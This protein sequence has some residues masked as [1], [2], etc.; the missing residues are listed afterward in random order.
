[1]TALAFQVSYFYNMLFDNL[2]S[3]DHLT[4]E[5]PYIKVGHKFK[6][7]D[8]ICYLFALMYYY[9]GIKDNIMYS[10]TQILYIK[11]YN[12]DSDLNKIMD[13]TLAF[14]T[15]DSNGNSLSLAE[16]ENIFDINKA[17]SEAD[18]NYNE[19]FK[20][21]RMKAFNLDVDIDELDA[22]LSQFQ[23]SLD[24]F[25]VY[26]YDQAIEHGFNQIITLRNFYSLNN[27]FYQKNIFSDALLPT[28]Y[29]NEIK[30]GFDYMLY[31]KT[32]INNISGK[33]HEYIICKIAIDN[34][35]DEPKEITL[36]NYNYD[37]YT[38]LIQ[39]NHNAN[40]SI[41]SKYMELLDG[42]DGHIFVM[43]NKHYAYHDGVNYAIYHKYRKSG[44]DYILENPDYYIYNNS[45]Y[46]L[47]NSNDLNEKY[48]NC[49]N[50]IDDN[51]NIISRFE[52]DD[53]YIYNDNNYILNP[54]TVNAITDGSDKRYFI[55][56]K[57][58]QKVPPEECYILSSD[59]KFVPLINTN[60][61]DNKNGTYNISKCFVI[62]DDKTIYYEKDNNGNTIYYKKLVDYY[63]E[64]NCY[65]YPENNIDKVYIKNKNGEYIFCTD[66][67]Y[68]KVEDDYI[69]ITNDKFFYTDNNNRKILKFGD[70]YIYKNGKYILDPDN[71]Y[72]IV[73][74][75][76]KKEYVLVKDLDKYKNEE[77]SADN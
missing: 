59:G 43:N 58:D 20:Y 6:F 57:E 40:V 66:K 16:R 15:K 23:L 27:S 51:G 55:V 22:W 42:N 63:N 35:G 24:D 2:Y 30:Y 48:K 5:I 9:N 19:A 70:Y 52:L 65:T 12:F 60:P 61:Y 46:K 11:G 39:F 75:N 44:N 26:D 73:E 38:K 41:V 29:N 1:M 28:Q 10:P 17:I 8:V 13:D 77:V 32:Y 74:K 3:E 47:I 71:C 54:K 45:Y 4:L 33:R 18:Y 50:V 49:I 7:M 68:K 64:N 14:T 53:N 37:Y 56:I 69:Q 25:I 67:Y 76:G 31:N 72:I 62:T 21:S 34:L 36:T